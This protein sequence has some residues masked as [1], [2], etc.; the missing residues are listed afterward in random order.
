[1]ISV[2]VCPTCNRPGSV[3]SSVR[4]DIEAL[5]DLTGVQPS[6]AASALTLARTIDSADDRTVASLAKE[7]RATLADLTG[8]GQNEPGDDGLGDLGAPE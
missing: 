7:L 8:A 4:D 2:D 6:L 3:E 5:G 1:M